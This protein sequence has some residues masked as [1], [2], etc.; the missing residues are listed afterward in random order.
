MAMSTTT[1]VLAAA[2]I[3]GGAVYLFTRPAT[4]KA[5]DKKTSKS[6]LPTT[7]ELPGVNDIPDTGDTGNTGSSD[8]DYTVPEFPA[9]NVISETAQVASAHAQWAS[10]EA[11]SDAAS[12][13]NGSVGLDW[14][15]DTL[16][17]VAFNVNFPTWETGVGVYPRL[18]P[19]WVQWNNAWKRMNEQMIPLVSATLATYGI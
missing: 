10:T 3:T 16:T 12:I 2:A 7:G 6:K 19:Q 14:L 11:A 8:E 5:A 13:Q 1:K 9:G 4:A 18:S 17:D 15:T